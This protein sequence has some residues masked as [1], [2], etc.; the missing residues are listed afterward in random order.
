[1]RRLFP[2]F[3]F[4]CIHLYACT[5]KYYLKENEN[6]RFFQ[7][8]NRGIEDRNVE[9]TL[10]D[11]ELFSAVSV[12]ADYKLTTYIR[13]DKRKREYIETQKIKQISFRNHPKGAFEGLFWGLTGGFLIGT[14][15]GLASGDDPPCNDGLFCLSFTAEEKAKIGGIILGATGALTGFIGGLSKGSL[16]IYKL[17]DEKTSIKPIDETLEDIEIELEE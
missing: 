11:G 16:E 5:H 1:M 4:F 8:L 9:I 2:V 7:A 15:I 6:S 10:L 17:A 12:K 13:T 14:F 3:V